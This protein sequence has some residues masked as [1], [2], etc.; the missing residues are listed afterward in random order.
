MASHLMIIK[1]N[2][3]EHRTP[4]NVLSRIVTSKQTRDIEIHKFRGTVWRTNSTPDD[5]YTP[6]G[7]E[8]ARGLSQP[9]GACY[10]PLRGN[11]R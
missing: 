10:L 2:L 7:A 4:S 11:H 5:P 6:T 9:H 8:C 3:T 1:T